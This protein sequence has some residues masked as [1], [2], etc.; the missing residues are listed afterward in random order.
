MLLPGSLGLFGGASEL[1]QGPS[2]SRWVQFTD[3]EANLAIKT[4][5]LPVMTTNYPEFYSQ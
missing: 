2:H 4:S 1:F 3:Q 5:G